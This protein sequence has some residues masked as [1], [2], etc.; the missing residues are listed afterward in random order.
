MHVRIILYF[1]IFLCF[2]ST[3]S[4]VFAETVRIALPINSRQ[5]RFAFKAAADYFSQT[6]PQY[7]ID[8][9][10]YEPVTYYSRLHYFISGKQPADIVFL[11]AGYRLKQMAAAKQIESLS[12]L[13]DNTCRASFT[14]E[15]QLMMKY[16]SDYFAVPFS[17]YTYGI[18]YNK[19]LFRKYGIDEPKN[20]S[21]FIKTC[22]K[23]KKFGYHP[24][25]F[26]GKN[27][28]A[29]SAWFGYI[30]IKL[31]GKEFH[32]AFMNGR[33]SMYDKRMEK[34]LTVMR[35]LS[36]NGYLIP[37]HDKMT[38]KE[39]SVYL[40]REKAGMMLLPNS[41]TSSLPSDVRKS[42]DFIRFPSITA[43]YRND[44]GMFLNTFAVLSNARNKNGAF[45]FLKFILRADTQSMLNK[46]MLTIPSNPESF[47]E[48]DC[49]FLKKGKEIISGTHNYSLY[50][51]S[52]AAW[53]INGRFSVEMN[54]IFT[55]TDIKLIQ[56][57]LEAIR[58]ERA[59]K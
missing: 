10:A 8:F 9:Y 57:R 13:W 43:E 21:D 58:L 47:I 33:I 3:A 35:T 2:F 44:E 31:N 53:D 34:A 14:K 41:F 40:L 59:V 49:R 29:A 6:Y 25:A 32:D 11:R 39:A 56:Y 55:R 19:N 54:S 45:K 42:V 46:M 48:D 37:N 15:Q 50:T 26:G 51:P 27:S 17:K 30:N 20:W 38:E 23:L 28:G 1:T 36:Q 5:E 24:I 16:G 7:K 52:E 4:N 12:P 22:E 18:F